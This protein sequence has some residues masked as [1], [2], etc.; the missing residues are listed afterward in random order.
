M[1]R[2]ADKYHLLVSTN[3]TFYMRVGSFDIKNS[4]C[5]KLSRV[6]HKLSPETATR[7]VL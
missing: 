6:D 7:G 3:N 4:L 5:K 2:N 1:K